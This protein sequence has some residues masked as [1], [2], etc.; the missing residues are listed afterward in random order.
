M[1]TNRDILPKILQAFESNINVSVNLMPGSY[2]APCSWWRR[3]FSHIG[4][5]ITF[6]IVYFMIQ[7]P[8]KS[9]AS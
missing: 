8:A 6:T 4:A 9:P 3:Q 5:I 2:I 1:A 7:S